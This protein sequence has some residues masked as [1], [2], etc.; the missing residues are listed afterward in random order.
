MSLHT[1]PA[2]WMGWGGGRR[3]GVVGGGGEV[4]AAEALFRN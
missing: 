2:G 3:G 4:L 1:T